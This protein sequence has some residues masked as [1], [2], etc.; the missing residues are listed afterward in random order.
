MFKL[1]KEDLKLALRHDQK[2][3]GLKSLLKKVM[4]KIN[5]QKK[6]EANIYGKLFDI[7]Y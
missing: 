4:A 1:A 6:K 3:K 7:D 5:K 2:N